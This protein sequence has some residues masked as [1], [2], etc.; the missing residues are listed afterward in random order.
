MISYGITCLDY[1]CLKVR[2]VDLKCQP[3]VKGNYTGFEVMFGCTM[4]ELILRRSENCNRCVANYKLSEYLSFSYCDY[5]L[6]V[7]CICVCM[8]AAEVIGHI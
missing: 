4:L 7:R 6:V 8:V 3:R 1:S 2:G 5:K